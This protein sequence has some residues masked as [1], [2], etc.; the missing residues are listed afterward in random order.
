MGQSS[1]SNDNI[2]KIH[3]TN[4]EL[5]NE[6]KKD[7]MSDSAIITFAEQII[8]ERGLDNSA[9]IGQAL[10]MPYFTAKNP[11]VDILEPFLRGVTKLVSSSRRSA[12]SATRKAASASVPT[13]LT[14]TWTTT[15]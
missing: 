13:P 14:A 12:G 9:K 15:R 7:N 8:R 4:P 5:F 10:I 3:F 11:S 2:Q 1:N 6:I